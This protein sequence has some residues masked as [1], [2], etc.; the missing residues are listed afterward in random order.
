M[1]PTGDTLMDGTFYEQLAEDRYLATEHTAG[2]WSDKTQHMGPPAALLAR[3]LERCEPRPGHAF[4]RLTFEVLGAVPVGELTVKAMVERSGRAVDLLAAELCVGDRTMVRARAW[5]LTQNDTAQVA[6]G[7]PAA[8]QPP[9]TAP[10]MRIPA[11]FGEGYLAATEWRSL[12]G[13]MTGTGRATVWGQPRVA[14]VAG[15]EATPLQRL[16]AIADSGNGVSNR[17]DIRTWM[18]INTELTIHLHRRPAG[19]WFALDA[20]TIVGPTGMGIASSVLH[21]SDG[22]I[23]RA[24][25]SLLIRAR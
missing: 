12:S 17:L 15:E 19:E 1:P 7:A 6:G 18:F 13:G 16:C 3:E 4:S 25:Q 24:A 8:L 10:A 5:R 11:E 21:D 14:L 9:D 20:E 22:P 2:P 23:G